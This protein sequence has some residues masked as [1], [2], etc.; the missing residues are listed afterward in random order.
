MAE[1]K[2]SLSKNEKRLLR[3]KNKANRKR[4]KFR[5][6]EWFRYVKLGDA[7]RKPRGKHSKLREQL[8]RRPRIVDAGFRTPVKV[9]GLHPSG[10]KEVIVY[11]PSDVEKIDPLKEAARISSSVGERK[12]EDIIEKANELNVKVLNGKV[13]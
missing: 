9:R 13:S 2:P 6:Q 3:I 8:G 7:W 11:N 10:F 5:R 4:T 12:R 1:P